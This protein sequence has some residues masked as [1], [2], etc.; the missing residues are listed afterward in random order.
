MNDIEEDNYKWAESSDTTTLSEK[1]SLS[2]DLESCLP[3][4]LAEEE[5]QL[6]LNKVIYCI[7]SFLWFNRITID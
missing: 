6:A 2:E 4:N 7:N 3:I 1:A 5:L